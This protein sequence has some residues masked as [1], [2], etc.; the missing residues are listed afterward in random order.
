MHYMAVVKKRLGV[1]ELRPA[2]RFRLSIGR[3]F[4]PR[5]GLTPKQRAWQ[6]QK[7]RDAR[8]KRAL[9][10][11]VL[12]GVPKRLRPRVVRLVQKDW[13]KPEIARKVARTPRG[14]LSNPTVLR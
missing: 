3:L 4:T 6:A 9:R 8:D 10:S 2:Q 7:A 11:L 5:D 1:K 13:W 14:R 12:F